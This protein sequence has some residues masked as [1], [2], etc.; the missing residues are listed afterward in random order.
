MKYCVDCSKPKSYVG[1]RCSSCV[2]KKLWGNPEYRKHMSEAH[3]GNIP[4]NLDN[5]IAFGKSKKGRK[6]NSERQLGKVPWNKGLKT[7]ENSGKNHYAWTGGKYKEDYR[8]RR[9]FRDQLQKEV[10]K[11]DNYTCQLCGAKGV[12]LQVDHIQ[13]WAEYVELRF[14]MDNCRTLCARCHY[15]ITFGKP[16]PE[17]IKGWGHNFL[18][19]RML[20]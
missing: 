7:P 15:E 20:K 17:N 2:K 10:F 13:S 18:D 6:Q 11:R 12:D 19:R 1:V 3:K 8:A 16:M 4:T 5:L 14:S 9:R